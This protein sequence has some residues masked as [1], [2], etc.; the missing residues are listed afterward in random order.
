MSHSRYQQKTDDD[1]YLVPKCPPYS[2]M[3]VVGISS[4]NVTV[5]NL[6]A[7]L[8]FAIHILV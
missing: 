1:S 7:V 4:V 8:K 2:L 5:A 6:E 3:V